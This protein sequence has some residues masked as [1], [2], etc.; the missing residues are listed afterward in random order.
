ML[1]FV[2]QNVGKDLA[3]DRLSGTGSYESEKAI[4]EPARCNPLTS[5]LLGDF[6]SPLYSGMAVASMIDGTVVY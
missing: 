1:C 4:G 2:R 5:N 3:D 6:V